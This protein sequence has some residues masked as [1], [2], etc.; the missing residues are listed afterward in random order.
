MIHII[1]YYVIA[2]I[3]A[4]LLAALYY[5][6][7]GDIGNRRHCQRYADTLLLMLSHYARRVRE[8]Y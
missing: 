8:G 1:Y 4:A 6:F 3:Y 7:I 2:M 5:W